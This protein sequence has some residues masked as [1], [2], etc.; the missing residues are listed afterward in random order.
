MQPLDIGHEEKLN[1]STV[2]KCKQEMDVSENSDNSKSRNNFNTVNQGIAKSEQREDRIY[3]VHQ[4]SEKNDELERGL[5]VPDH[6]LNQG[7]DKALIDSLQCPV[8]GVVCAS[9]NRLD[10]HLSEHEGETP[11]VCP[12]CNKGFGRGGGLKAHMKLHS[13]EKPHVCTVCNKAFSLK[14]NLKVHLRLHTGEKP[15]HCPMC[16]KAF[17]QKIS[18]IKHL[19]VH[20]QQQYQQQQQEG[21]EVICDI[22]PQ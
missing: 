10:I 14:G 21:E 11:Y 1:T 3:S 6:F 22:K 18:L 7:C 5:P 4:I 16:T 19:S 15:F 20:K 9:R 13:G 8:C 17:T 2:N 12:I